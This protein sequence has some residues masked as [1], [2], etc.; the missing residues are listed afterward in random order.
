MMNEVD[1]IEFISEFH[2]DV[3]DPS[4]IS[5]IVGAWL[6]CVTVGM[7][8]GP[9][10]GQANPLWWIFVNATFGKLGAKLDNLNRKARDLITRGFILTI[11]VMFLS[12]GMGRF[13]EKIA[14]QYDFGGVSEIVFLSLTM[15]AG[16]VWFGLLQLFF[17]MRDERVS[18]GAYY[19]IART[20][21]T[22]LSSLDDYG[23]TRTGMMMAVRSF[24]KAFVSPALWYLML[25]LPGAFLYAGLAALS[26]RFG[27]DGFTKGFGSVPMALEKLMGVVPDIFA[28]ILVALAGLFTPTGGMTRAVTALF[29]FKK[30]MPYQQGG[31]PVT[32]MA[33][34][35]K[36]KLGGAVNDT[37]GSAMKRAWVGP[38]NATAQLEKNH[39]KRGIYITLM[40]HLL[41]VAGLA[42]SFLFASL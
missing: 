25:G 30:S 20:T 38:N 40:A 9:M 22:N 15:A 27:K 42:A 17:A 24:S 41:F 33:Y 31:M 12:F 4:R 3:F 28:G 6:L 14:L 18:D 36:I 13:L 5:V 11:I 39:L 19:K 23:I 21:R 2:N 7:V 35:L 34:S 29:M 1:I 37:D 10:F 32:A 8:S 16:S 26:W